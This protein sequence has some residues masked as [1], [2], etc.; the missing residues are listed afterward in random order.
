MLCLSSFPRNVV[1]GGSVLFCLERFYRNSL[2]FSLWCWGVRKAQKEKYLS[3]GNLNSIQ[4]P[5]FL[6]F[7]S[8]WIWIDAPHNLT[9]TARF[10]RALYL[11]ANAHGTRVSFSSGEKRRKEVRRWWCAAFINNTHAHART[12]QKTEREK[13]KNG[14]RPTVTSRRRWRARFWSRGF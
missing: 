3:T 4:N 1:R 5:K 6:F 2:F 8:F 12:L 10:A 11:V 9:T 7:S 14:K 13:K